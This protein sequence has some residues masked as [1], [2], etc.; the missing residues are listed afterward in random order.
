M[1]PR[2]SSITAKGSWRASRSRNPSTSSRMKTCLVLGQARYCT[3]FCESDTE[4]GA[5]SSVGDSL[6]HIGHLHFSSKPDPSVRPQVSDIPTHPDSQFARSAF[7]SKPVMQQERPVQALYLKE[8]MA[9]CDVYATSVPVGPISLLLV[10]DTV[11]H[12]CWYCPSNRGAKAK[13]VFYP[14]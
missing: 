2:A 5:T 12:G 11:W 9:G 8:V 3:A 6:I 10:H 7:A 13:Y 14:A 1:S 4:N